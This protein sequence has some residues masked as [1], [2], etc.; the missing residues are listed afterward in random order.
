MVSGGIWWY[1]VVSGGIVSGGIVGI[2]WYLEGGGGRGGGGGVP[3]FPIPYGMYGMYGMY[4]NG[5]YGM[6]KG[7]G[8]RHLDSGHESIWYVWY[9]CM[10][11]MHG[12]ASPEQSRAGLLYPYR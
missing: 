9:V 1:L 10:V 11:C 2:L 12:M 4:G 5:K 6:A 7:D 8:R 3:R